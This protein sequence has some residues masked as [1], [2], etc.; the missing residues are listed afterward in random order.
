MAARILEGKDINTFVLRDSSVRDAY[1]L[2]YVDDENGITHFLMLFQP[3]A[4]WHIDG[5]V[6]ND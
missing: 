3:N 6:I 4:G 2:S 1:A 5:E